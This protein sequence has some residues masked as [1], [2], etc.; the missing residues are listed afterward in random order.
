[1]MMMMMVVELTFKHCVTLL[2]V[3][4]IICNKTMTR[5]HK[6]DASSL[7]PDSSNNEDSTSVLRSGCN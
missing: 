4:L 7:K 1:M 3:V 5:E 2:H 6:S